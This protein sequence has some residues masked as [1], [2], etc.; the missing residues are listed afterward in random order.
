MSLKINFLSDVMFLNASHLEVNVKLIMRNLHY[1][2]A[3]W[4]L[5]KS[6]VATDLFSAVPV[7]S[8]L[9]Q[10]LQDLSPH[11]HKT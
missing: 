5:L 8:A 7:L 3:I 11:I 10:D 6:E 1:S 4:V 9:N 2:K